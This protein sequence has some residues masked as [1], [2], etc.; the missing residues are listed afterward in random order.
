MNLTSILLEELFE[1]L[2]SA[3]AAPV[4][5]LA[6][7]PATNCGEDPEAPPAC[8]PELPI[9]A[10]DSKLGLEPSPLNSFRID[11]NLLFCFNLFL[12]FSYN[13]TLDWRWTGFVAVAARGCWELPPII[14]GK[15][16]DGGL[17]LLLPKISS[18][19]DPPLG[20]DLDLNTIGLV[21]PSLWSWS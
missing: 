4:A 6:A 15:S 20:K 5:P 1:F 17:V 19:S 9:S 21:W 14:A 2:L 11:E 12:S 3:L 7:E 10:T 13:S 18:I 8:E 16:L